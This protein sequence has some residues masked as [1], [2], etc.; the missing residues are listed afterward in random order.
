MFFKSL[1]RT[2]MQSSLMKNSS[3]L[4]T[5]ADGLFLIQDIL[6]VYVLQIPPHAG[7]RLQTV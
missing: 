3:C 4:R 6:D 2:N 1:R 5:R 7:N